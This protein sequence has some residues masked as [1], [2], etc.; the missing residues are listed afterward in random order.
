[1]ECFSECVNKLKYAVIKM[2]QQSDPKQKLSR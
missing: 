2:E 1:M